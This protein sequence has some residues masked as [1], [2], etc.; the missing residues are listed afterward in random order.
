MQISVEI[1]HNIVF[2]SVTIH[3]FC[4]INRLKS[5]KS[6]QDSIVDYW[7]CMNSLEIFQ[8]LLLKI[9]KTCKVV[10]HATFMKLI[11]VNN[12]K[13]ILTLV[14]S[15]SYIKLYSNLAHLLSGTQLCKSLNFI[16]HI[17]L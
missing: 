16:P 5:L 9:P 8:N 1:K 2:S 10:V 7:E 12:A 17:L 15:S 4:I 13:Q 11:F 6:A 14:V 3:L